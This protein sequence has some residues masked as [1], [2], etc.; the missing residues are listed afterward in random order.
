[1]TVPSETLANIYGAAVDPALWFSAIDQCVSHVGA[2]SAALVHIDTLGTHA[3]Q[4]NVISEHIRQTLTDEDVNC[5]VTDLS[6]YEM[7]G[8]QLLLKCE[9]QSVYR[10][11]DLWP[12][13]TQLDQRADYQFLQRKLGIRRKLAARLLDN[14]RYI[15]TFGLHFSTELDDVPADCAA[16]MDSLLP[17]VAKAVEIG[18][19][20]DRLQKQYAAVLTALNHVGIGLCVIESN[21]VVLVSNKEATRILESDSGLK[22]GRDKRL[23]CEHHVDTK[24]LAMCIEQA[25]LSSDHTTTVAERIISLQSEVTDN[26]PVILEV[27]PIRDHLQEID[28]GNNAVLVQIVDVSC[29]RHCS[30]EAFSIA[31]GL[32]PAEKEVAK[33]LLQGLQNSEIADARNT[34]VETTKSQ[35]SQVMYKGDVR[36]RVQLI[37][38]ILKTDPPVFT[39][40]FD[41][42]LTEDQV[43]DHSKE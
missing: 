16:R 11:I 12:D 17:H 36:S 33:L 25:S 7:E 8:H 22:L 4:L 15:D 9:V 14:K 19:I 43:K 1:M 32:T 42:E 30:I 34:S 6:K 27:S 2:T 38:L 28:A 37:R 40:E 39:K 3:Y 5:W 41:K 13:A 20:F 24:H 23:T 35:V 21:G 10:D 31:Y 26:N 29:H 18:A